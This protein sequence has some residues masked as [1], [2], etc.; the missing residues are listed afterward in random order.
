LTG[1]AETPAPAGWRAGRTRAAA[2]WLFMGLAFGAHYWPVRGTNFGGFDEWVFLWLTAHG[3]V[4]S[5][6]SNRPL[7]LFWTWPAALWPGTFRSYSALHV[8]YL[9]LGGLCVWGLARR[10]VAQGGFA[11][12]AG[13]IALT[14]APMDFHRLTTVQMIHSGFA[15]T[16]TLALLLAVEAWTRRLPLLSVLSALVAFLSARSY[17]GVLPVLFGVP[18][19]LF[20]LPQGPRGW[21]LARWSAAPLAAAALAATLTA[22]PLLAASGAAAYQTD[23]LKFD[24][25]PGR[26]AWRLLRQYGFHLVPLAE[27]PSRSLLTTSG[28]LAASAC[29]AGF[30]L[31][32]PRVAEDR[33][34]GQL[35]RVGVLGLLL[36]GLGYLGFAS[37]AALTTPTRAQFLAGPGIALLLAAALAAAASPLRGRARHLLLGALTAYVVLLGSARTARIQEAWNQ[38]SYYPRQHRALAEL[39]RQAPDLAP[40]TLVLLVDDSGAWPMTMTFRHAVDYLYQGRAIGLV[41]GAE[42]YMYPAQVHGEGLVI[43]PAKDIQRAWGVR[44]TRHRAD[45]VLVVRFQPGV[46]EGR[47]EIL[48]VWPAGLPR[49]PGRYAPRDRILPL[50]DPPPRE[51]GV[52][53]L[54]P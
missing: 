22:W 42:P 14:W 13:M 33:T 31:V 51:R 53:W 47:L 23:L 41:W 4:D 29:A 50:R 30:A 37:S 12:A 5:P 48:D 18:L 54:L 2:E 17:E 7:N 20:V 3:I 21:A 6:Y 34:A 44:E 25:H 28:A 26:V 46:P 38:M 11:V 52:L 27:V 39:T 40:N 19:V 10:L 43:S 1:G 45:E 16:M 24:P 36:A 49:I 15:L 35:L 9:M 8:G 32:V